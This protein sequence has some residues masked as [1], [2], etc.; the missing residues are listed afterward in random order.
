MVPRQI[1]P[2]QNGRHTQA[3]VGTCHIMRCLHPPTAVAVRA[4]VQ[5][6][7]Q[8]RRRCIANARRVLLVVSG[9]IVVAAA[10]DTP[11]QEF[12]G[13]IPS[14]WS[15]SWAARANPH[16]RRPRVHCRCVCRGVATACGNAVSGAMGRRWNWAVTV[17]VIYVAIEPTG[18]C[19]RVV[20]GPSPGPSFCSTPIPCCRHRLFASQSLPQRRASATA[21]GLF[22]HE[23]WRHK[24]HTSDWLVPLKKTTSC[25]CR[26]QLEAAQAS[27]RSAHWHNCHRADKRVRHAT[28]ASHA[29]AAGRMEHW[30]SV[31][32]GAC[33]HSKKHTHH[34]DTAASARP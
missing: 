8:Q 5:C 30:Q 10:N 24:N 19:R 7:T 22:L 14:I 34:V 17:A 1:G 32:D 4:H 27:S 23:A 15:C 33:L 28:C 31:A 3:G 13:G 21:A 25:S 20:A 2:R 9:P 26:S 29:L 11:A 16:T 18:K 6:M 12:L